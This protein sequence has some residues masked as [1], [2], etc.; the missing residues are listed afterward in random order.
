MST[1]PGQSQYQSVLA[2]ATNNVL[3]SALG[4]DGQ[5]QAAAAGTS[6]GPLPP[7]HLET[8]PGFGSCSGWAEEEEA[9]P[10]V[11]Q[12]NQRRDS[13]RTSLR[14]KSANKRRSVAG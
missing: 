2:G 6:S 8:Y 12:V 9:A 5:Q 14:E 10:A 11:K 1:K 13:T 4:S 3:A 7:K